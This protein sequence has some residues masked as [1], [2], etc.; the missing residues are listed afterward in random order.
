MQ[1]LARVWKGRNAKTSL[2]MERRKECK[3]LLDCGKAVKEGMQKL[4]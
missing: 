1:K 3:S 4:A 2:R